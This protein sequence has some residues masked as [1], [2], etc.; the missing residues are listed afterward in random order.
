MLAIPIRRQRRRLGVSAAIIMLVTISACAQRLTVSS[1]PVPPIPA[2]EARVWVYRDY[3]PSETLNMTA[4]DLNGAYA[5]YSQ[6]GGAFYRDVPPGIYHVTVESFGKDFN[7]STSVALVPGQQ[8]YIKIETLR[9]WSSYGTRSAIG[10]DTFYARLIPELLAR[11][12]IAQSFY[13][14]GS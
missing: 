12:E 9:S 7:Q 6:L 10:R 13:D 4:V 11:A 1:A 8:A 3:L 5:G 14:G 2:G